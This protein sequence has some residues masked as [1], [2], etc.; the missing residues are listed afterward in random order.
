M[1]LDIFEKTFL[2]A[3]S[4]NL[5]YAEESQTDLKNTSPSTAFVV[6][7]S[8]DVGLCSELCISRRIPGDS[9]AGVS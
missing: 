3:V 7:D 6:A 9:E 4:L 1:L 8:E 5:E 2:G